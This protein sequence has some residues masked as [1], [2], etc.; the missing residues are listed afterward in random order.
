M[1]DALGLA[2]A[3]ADE[4]TGRQEFAAQSGLRC[5]VVRDQPSGDPIRVEFPFLVPGSSGVAPEVMA[6][7][8]LEPTAGPITA[9][10]GPPSWSGAAA[11]HPTLRWDL[12]A[13]S[14]V[15]GVAGAGGDEVLFAVERVTKPWDAAGRPAE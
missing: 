10:L 13:T 2:G 8:L 5:A 11:G 6:P 1:L 12:G 15:L 3:N 14:L 7:R 9:V 4:R